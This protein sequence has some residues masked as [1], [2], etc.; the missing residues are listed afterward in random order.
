MLDLSMLT[1]AFNMALD[2]VCR[3]CSST[4]QLGKSWVLGMTTQE[5]C[6]EVPLVSRTMRTQ[7]TGVTSLARMCYQM[8]L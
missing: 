2:V 3:L 8:V 6:L 4:S 1:M 7:R 5:V